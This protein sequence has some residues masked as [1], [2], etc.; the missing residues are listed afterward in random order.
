MDDDKYSSVLWYA[1]GLLGALIPMTLLTGC[2]STDSYGRYLSAQSA[3]IKSQKPILKIT[4]QPGQPITGLASIEVYGPGMNIQQ[5][6]D[7]EWARVVTAG[8]QTVGVVGGIVAAGQAS[9]DLV[10]AV[11]GLG[12]SSSVVTN[13]DNRTS[14]RHDIANA[15][16]QTATPTVV[17]P[18]VVTQPQPLVVQPQVVLP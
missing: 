6:K 13:T 15:Y 18:V 4:A 8:I 14:D 7:N 2:A 9:Q 3:A 5:E 12:I 11:G 16:N 1:I 10:N 17:N